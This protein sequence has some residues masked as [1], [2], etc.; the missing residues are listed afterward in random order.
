MNEAFLFTLG[1]VL[2]G[3]PGGA[4]L[5]LA[6]THPDDTRAKIKHGSSAAFRLL[7]KLL[8]ER[9]PRQLPDFIYKK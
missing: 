3:I 6:W 5:A 4:L 1:I 9:P 7:K 8:P 2:V